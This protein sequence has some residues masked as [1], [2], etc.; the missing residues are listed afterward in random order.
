MRLPEHPGE[1]IQYCNE[2]WDAGGDYA[3]VLPPSYY[4]TLFAPALRRFLNTSRQSQTESPIS[5]SSS[6]NFPG[7]RGGLDLSFD[8]IINA[9][10]E[11]ANI[12]LGV[13]PYGR[14]NGKA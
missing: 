9:G 3:L 14:K 6:H 10:A 13:K 11:D 7:R 4:A 1:T 2:A 8:I 12:V 5:P